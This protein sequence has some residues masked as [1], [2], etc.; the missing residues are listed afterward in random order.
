[1]PNI[2]NLGFVHFSVSE[3]LDMYNSDKILINKE[4]QR[5]F[6]WKLAQRRG[7][8]TSIMKGYSM[9]VLVVWEN[10]HGQ[11]EI[12]DGQQR[13][14][15][16][17]LYLKGKFRNENGKR[18]FELNKTE[19][20]EIQAY[21]VCCIKLLTSLNEEQISDTFT[22][23]QEGTPLN[24]PEKVNAFRGL[25]RKSYMFLFESNQ[26]FFGRTKNHRFRARFLAAQ[27]LL[28]EIKSNFSSR[29]FPSMKY[30][31]FKNVNQE[32]KETIPRRPIGE[33]HRNI[34]F[35]GTYLFNEIGAISFRDW[36]SLY[37]LISYLSKKK[38][39]EDGFGLHFRKFTLRFMK[40]LTSFSIYDL[41]PPKDMDKK[42]FDRFMRYKQFGRQATNSESIRKRFNIIIYEF[43]QFHP[44]KDKDPV[45]LF[46]EEEKIRAYFKQNGLCAHCGD[47]L[48][49]NKAVCHH[50]DEHAKGG[51][52]KIE[53]AKMVH[54]KCH[55][56]IHQKTLS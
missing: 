24:T 55:E 16:I 45:R 54:P 15:T 39:Y 18:F 32:Y 33:C 35:L 25:F 17:A 29:L 28:L 41:V 10:R 38:A 49:F 5:S 9:G 34:D 26:K 1:M 47:A 12:L 20:A 30:E 6:I 43:N 3:F 8:I 40:K 19:Q 50:K 23:L 37:L 7:L 51:P 36:I 46:N 21:S 31:D 52:T 56:E 14:R 44:L 53:N 13:V 27:F 22:R 42:T 11:L 2:P 48:D 4:Y